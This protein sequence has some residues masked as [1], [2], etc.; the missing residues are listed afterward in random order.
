MAGVTPLAWWACAETGGESEH[1][2][3]EEATCCTKES[4]NETKDIKAKPSCTTRIPTCIVQKTSGALW[5][6]HKACQRLSHIMLG[7]FN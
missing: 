6:D 7:K 2:R 3:D 1:H 5:F 4:R